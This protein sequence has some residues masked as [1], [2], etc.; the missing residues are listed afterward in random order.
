MEA[1]PG[2]QSLP[3]EEEV[4]YLESDGKPMAEA[5][6]DR[7]RAELEALRKRQTGP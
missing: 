6:L 1:I 3:E 2:A 5:E 4:Y 7:L